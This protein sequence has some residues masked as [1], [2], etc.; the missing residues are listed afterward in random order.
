MKDRERARRAFVADAGW[1][2]ATQAP[3]AGD[4][5][6][7]RYARLTQGGA[8][9]VLMDDPPPGHAVAAFVRIARLLRG[10]GYSAPE[11]LAADD[12]RG[13]ALLEDFGDD[14]FSALLAGP[15]GASL[16]RTLYEAATDLLIDLHRRPVPPDLRRYDADWMLDD[17]KLF[18]ESVAGDTSHADMAAEFEA[19]WRGPLEEAAAGPQALC[20]RDFHAG[21]LMWLPARGDRSDVHALGRVGLLDFQDTRIGPAAYDLVSLLQDA[22]RDLG[23]GLEAAMLARYLQA[24]PGLDEP[25]FRAAYAILG[26]QRAVRIV[27]VFHRLARRDGKPAY[28]AHLPRVWGHLD[29]NLAHP[30]LASVRAWFD[31]RRPAHGS[32]RAVS[33]GPERGMV[34][35]AGLGTRMRAVSETIPKPLVLLAGK[36]LLAYALESLEVAGVTEI[37]VNTHH[38]A[39][40]IED[41]LAGHGARPG[42]PRIHVSREEERLETGGGVRQALR[43]LGDD[44]FYVLNSDAVI[45]DQGPPALARLAEAWEGEAMDALLLLCPR[46]SALGCGGAGDFFQGSDGRLSRRGRAAA[47]PYVF[48]GVQLLHP[49]LFAGAPDGA[50]SLNRHYDEA[51][52]AGRLFGVVHRGHMLHVGSPE[53]LAAAE[54]YLAGEGRDGEG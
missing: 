32:R 4:A 54:R 1:G 51:I 9:A 37:V 27:G 22:R 14:S 46:D 23:S 39:A 17:A 44:A 20:L 2:D 21:N 42:A 50:Y 40:Q 34:L 24:S 8:T 16:E 11:V 28:L 6:A 30:A 15:A 41:F 7:R 45:A 53:G 36:P 13:F 35:A 10:M 47:A 48:T 19:A 3:L 25:T 33:A 38:L 18:L 12:E 43:W 29:R 52:G 5:S 26:A 49:R 31:R